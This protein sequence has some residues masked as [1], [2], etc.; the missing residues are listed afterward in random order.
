LQYEGKK[1]V[2]HEPVQTPI[3]PPYAEALSLLENGK[4]FGDSAFVFDHHVDFNEIDIVNAEIKNDAMFKQKKMMLLH[5]SSDE[6]AI[7]KTSNDQD[8][9]DE[10]TIDTLKN[11][12]I[13]EEDN[14]I[15]NN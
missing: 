14:N 11:L 5:T 12:Y 13:F 3:A 7:A 6:N 15:D 9:E 1:Y 8:K 2:Y 10:A 4:K